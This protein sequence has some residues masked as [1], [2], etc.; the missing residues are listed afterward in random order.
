MFFKRLSRSRSN[1]Q[2]Y[3]D[4]QYTQPSPRDSKANSASYDDDKFANDKYAVAGEPDSQRPGSSRQSNQA[5]QFDNKE[6]GMYAR[7]SQPTEVS[8]GQYASPPV[9]AGGARGHGM[10]NGGYGSYD[11]GDMRGAP[12]AKSESREPA[13]DL[14]LQAFNQALRPYTDKVENL[15][16]EIADLRAYIDQLESQRGD[17]HAWIDKRGLRPDVPPSI[18]HQMDNASHTSS[19]THAAATLNAQL[20][21]KITIVN[22]DLHRLQDDLNDSL[23]TPSFSACMLKFLPDIARLSALPSGPRYA[24][25]LLLKLGGNLNSHG[26]LENGDED[27]LQERRAFYSRLDNAMVDIVRGRF[28]EEGE[29]WGVQREIKRI[30]K[31]GAYLRNWGVEP[32][33]PRTLEVMRDGSGGGMPSSGDRHAA[34]GATASPPDY[35]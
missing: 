15:E 6:T 21:R 35:Q 10:A 28:R 19:P 17:V 29:S 12:A 24:F 23:P 30:E 31:T 25:D 8:G 7:Q 14:L 11:S 16:S 1:S 20:D 32:Y 13:P 26:G 2:S 33:F 34:E 18:A 5:A 3:I 4:N 9:S 22:F 27:D